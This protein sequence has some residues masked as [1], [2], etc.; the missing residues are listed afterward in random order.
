MMPDNSLKSL[1]K[2]ALNINTLTTENYTQWC[3]L[4][5]RVWPGL[6]PTL[7]HDFIAMTKNNNTSP[8]I[9]IDSQLIGASLNL[10]KISPEKQLSLL[11]HMLGVDSNYQ[12]Q[13]IGQQ[14]MQENFKIAR[15]YQLPKIQLTSDP[16][17]TNNVSL[18]LHHSR[19]HS[20]TYIP[21]LYTK[22]NKSGGDQHRGLPADRLL[23]ET[24][25]DS[26][27]VQNGI[28]PSEEKYIELIQQNPD[29]LLTPSSFTTTKI[30]IQS[31]GI[32]LVETPTNIV[33][34][35]QQSMNQ[36]Q[37]WRQFQA[38]VLPQLFNQGYT[39]INRIKINSSSNKSAAHYIVCINNF[40]ENNPL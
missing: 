33:D 22:L 13:G 2:E 31:S 20:N 27:W 10:I 7:E 6:S 15:K 24:N 16:L 25:P 29:C 39:A 36:A 40:N 32:I 34:L 9:F 30:A 19:M 12:S 8:T 11:V 17:E 35:K 14:L 28:L 5:S 21:D 38:Q 18:Y 26:N 23:Y 3:K 37:A 4:I 1:E